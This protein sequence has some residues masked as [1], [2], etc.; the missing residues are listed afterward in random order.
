MKVVEQL[1]KNEKE[2]Q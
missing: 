1:Q 2:E